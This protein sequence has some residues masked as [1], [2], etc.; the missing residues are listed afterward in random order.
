MNPF[1]ILGFIV[2]LGVGFVH[3]FLLKQTQKR[4]K[5]LQQKNVD[6][7][8]LLD[9]KESE[10]SSIKLVLKE[11]N[12]ESDDVART[13][14]RR[15]L[16]LTE[17]NERLRELD[18]IKSEFVSIA[19]HQLRTPLT[20]I[21]WTLNALLNDEIGTLDDNQKKF[22]SDGLT[23]THRLIEL[24]NDLLDT[25]RLEEGKFGFSFKMQL[26][27][28]ILERTMKNYELLAKEKGIELKLQLP[29][30]D[31][32]MLKLD[33]EKIG[34]VLDNLVDNALKYTIPGGKITVKVFVQ[35]KN[36]IVKVADTGIGIPKAQFHRLFT[37]F[38]RA[39]NAQLAE[40]SGTGLGLYVSYN[41]V[42]RHK[43]TLSF[44]SSEGEGST[45][46]LSLPIFKQV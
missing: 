45:F 42:K 17:S 36:V 15:D 4:I 11:R 41:I 34:I 8:K 33:T 27:T 40:T 9:V 32:P 43:G 28:P 26:L 44:E 38:F 24:I 6:A 5:E 19:A 7:L 16:E 18:E 37:K 13:L 14:V 12:K 23:S 2:F 21:K 20:G 22:V 35:K 1:L 3:I 10:I 39:V 29:K 30:A 31:L 25:A 46:I